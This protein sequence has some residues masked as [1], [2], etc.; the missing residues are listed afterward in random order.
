ME[1]DLI[2]RIY[3]DSNNN[4]TVKIPYDLNLRLMI[5]DDNND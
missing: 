2:L 1:T 3:N 4:I 5:S